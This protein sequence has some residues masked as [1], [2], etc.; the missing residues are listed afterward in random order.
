[1][2]WSRAFWPCIVVPPALLSCPLP[3]KRC[4]L[5]LHALAS[6]F[7]SFYFPMFFPSLGGGGGG[8]DALLLRLRSLCFPMPKQNSRNKI[9]L[10]PFL[11]ACRLDRWLLIFCSL[12]TFLLLHRVT[13]VYNPSSFA[14]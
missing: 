10:S 11:L 2:T 3:M 8:G 4:S 6:A 1:M 9:R 13:Q 5:F 7:F 12:R 14:F